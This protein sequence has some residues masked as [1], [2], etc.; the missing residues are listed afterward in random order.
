MSQNETNKDDKEMIVPEGTDNISEKE[1]VSPEE[2]EKKTGTMG[3][4]CAEETKATADANEEVNF[5]AKYNELYDKYLRQAAEYDNFRKR[6]LKEKADLIKYGGESVLT[7]LLTVID[8]LER[9]LK[10]IDTAQDMNAMKEGINLIYT[11]FKEYLSQQG[12][13]EI[14]AADK[15]FNVD[16]H[17][18]ITKIPSEDKKG[19]VVDILQKGYYLNDKVIRFSKV[20]IGE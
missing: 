12:V 10:T 4:E 14:E 11:K 5:E 18:A 1:P 2:S 19:K 9:G 20:V 7:N 15:E 3:E 16:L 8:D 13:K 6:T 17:E